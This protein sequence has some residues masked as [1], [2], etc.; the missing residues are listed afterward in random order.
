MLLMGG[1]VDSP[2]CI[3]CQCDR[4]ACSPIRPLVWDGKG[5][6]GCHGPPRGHGCRPGAGSQLADG[7]H[8]PPGPPSRGGV[9]LD[10]CF[11]PL[12]PSEPPRGSTVRGWCVGRRATRMSSTGAAAGKL[13][14]AQSQ[15]IG[16]RKAPPPKGETRSRPIHTD[17]AFRRG[18]ECFVFPKEP[19]RQRAALAP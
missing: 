17:K 14:R 4:Q 13:R 12:W 6:Y 9:P 10:C 3:M 2:L 1:L 11:P 19:L 15:K 7:Q 8:T 18:V 16:W 5:G